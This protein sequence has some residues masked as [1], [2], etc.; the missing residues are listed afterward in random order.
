[1]LNA[2]ILLSNLAWMAACF[3]A[4]REFQRALR[5]PGETQAKVL[6]K[7][8]ARNAN[9]EFGRAYGFSTIRNAKDYQA[10]VPISTYDDL[11]TYINRIRNGETNVLTTEAVTLFEKTSGSSSAAKYIP[12]TRSLQQEFQNAVRACLPFC[13]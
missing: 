12:Y 13:V 4:H 11:A 6:R 2:S 8:L 7:L 3:P 10:R 5:S 9:S 1:M